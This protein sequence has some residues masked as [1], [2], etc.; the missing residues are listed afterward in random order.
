VTAVDRERWA[1]LDRI[2]DAA[3]DRPEAQRP[4]F[5][6]V[7][8]HGDPDL[9]RAAG[10][11]L[12][13]HSRAASF[14]EGPLASMDEQTLVGLLDGLGSGRQP[15]APTTVDRYRILA[16]LGSG[17]MG[18]VYAAADDRLHRRVAIK[19][20]REH[21]AAGKG[22]ARLR[23]EGRILACIS[24]P[25]LVAVFDIL[26]LDGRPAI[27]MELVE[28]TDLVHLIG[29]NGLE[30]GEALT[31]A[32]QIGEGLAAAHAAGVVHRDLKA[33]NV[34]VSAGRRVKILDFG[35]ASLGRHRQTGEGD[36]SG[37]NP[38]VGSITALA[39]EQVAGHQATPASDLFSFG[40]LLHQ[41]I[42]GT[43]PFAGASVME[44]ME[45]VRHLEPAPLRATRP[46]VPG[47]LEE[48][49]ASLLS[50]DPARRP[51]MGEVLTRL[52]R[53]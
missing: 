20:V 7:A 49:T 2:V 35:V 25:N 43:H 13:A 26:D 11:L 42:T 47:W 24:H 19:V 8:C 18:V 28:G 29:P 39:P 27:V 40:S 3:L 9:A 32:Q 46:E 48:L 6:A 38:T 41:M 53:G 16:T 22:I 1:R 14:L 37:Q 31:I 4:A 36:P 5:V 34:K 12:A 33:E 50:K 15:P 21:L 52:R 30:V 44:V 51:G 10:D 17:G 45:R 23:R